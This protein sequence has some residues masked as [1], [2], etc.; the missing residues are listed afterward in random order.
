[1]SVLT[2]SIVAVILLATHFTGDLS[3]NL[4]NIVAVRYIQHVSMGKESPISV[5]LYEC[6]VWSMRFGNKQA[7]EALIYLNEVTGNK[8]PNVDPH[9]LWLGFND[10]QG[11]RQGR[12][13]PKSIWSLIDNG[14]ARFEAEEMLIGGVSTPNRFVEVRAKENVKYTVL[15][16]QNNHLYTKLVLPTTGIYR[17]TVRAIDWPPTPLRIRMDVGGTSEEFIW[18]SGDYTWQDQSKLVI[19]PRGMTSVRLTYLTPKGNRT[20]NAS[21]DY[22]EMERLE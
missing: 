19:L 13:Y 16:W 11:N 21:I 14:Q 20:Q 18:K 3:Y 22:L 1:M 5:T 10:W 12:P 2:L 15:Y 17:F 4:C 8:W 9:V 7:D 6:L